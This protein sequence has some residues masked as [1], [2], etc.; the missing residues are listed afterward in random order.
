MKW[1][2][3]FRNSHQF[4]NPNPYVA[5][6]LKRKPA[7]FEIFPAAAVDMSNFILDKLD[8]FS[9]EMLK[10]YFNNISPLTDFQI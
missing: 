3:I 9:I 1:S 7:I 10:E 8:Q 2:R 4:P 6:G 5:N